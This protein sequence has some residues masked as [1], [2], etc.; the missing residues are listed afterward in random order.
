MLNNIY[1]IPFVYFY[2]TRLKSIKKFISWMIIYTIPVSF[3]F[4][5][6]TGFNSDVIPNLFISLLSI[7]LIY[8]LYEVG[9]IY[10]DTETIKTEKKPT[11]RLTENQLEFYEKNK[12][13]IYSSRIIVSIL[14]SFLLVLITSENILPFL[15]STWMLLIV[16]YFYNTTR[17]LYNLPLHFILVSI[18]YASVSIIFGQSYLVLFYLI[19]LFPVINLLERTTESRFN[20]SNIINKPFKNKTIGRIFYYAILSLFSI[21]LFLT[22]QS[23]IDYIFMI[24]SLYYFIYRTSLFLL[25]V[26]A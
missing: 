18:R 3:S 11:I 6:Y 8:S 15:F 2:K 23:S 16:Y 25:R 4:T 1:Y 7:T 21:F 22:N 9:Y 26:K 14:I 12:T 17:S 5:F 19:L 24:I 20:I 10:N 13:I